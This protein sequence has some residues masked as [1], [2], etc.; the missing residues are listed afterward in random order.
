MC[1]PLHLG[2]REPARSEATASLSHKCS[3]SREVTQGSLDLV[4]K[5][6]TVCSPACHGTAHMP[7]QESKTSGFW[8]MAAEVACQAPDCGPGCAVQTYLQPNRSR[9]RF[10]AAEQSE[11]TIFLNTHLASEGS[12]G[13][14]PSVWQSPKH[15]PSRGKSS[16]VGY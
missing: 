5:E 16:R 8:Q 1:R 13:L 14:F 11:K 6:R 2:S 12:C 15:F 10:P 7:R 3:S 9:S 4:L